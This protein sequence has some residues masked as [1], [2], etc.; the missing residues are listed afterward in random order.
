MHV[1]LKHPLF[2]KYYQITFYI[3][4][5]WKENTTAKKF[6]PHTANLYRGAFTLS[7]RMMNA[8]QNLEYYMMIEVIEPFWHEFI[9]K[10]KNVS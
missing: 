6:S 2:L 8:I 1:S 3:L 5:I 4:R 9:T 10:I 7:Q